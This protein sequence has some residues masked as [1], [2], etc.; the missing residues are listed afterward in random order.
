MFAIECLFVNDIIILPKSSE[1]VQSGMLDP[2][3]LFCY[4]RILYRCKC[5]VGIDGTYYTILRYTLNHLHDEYIF[6]WHVYGPKNYVI[7]EYSILKSTYHQLIDHRQQSYSATRRY[8]TQMMS[9]YS[10][11]GKF[12]TNLLQRQCLRSIGYRGGN[13]RHHG[14]SSVV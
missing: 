12:C 8:S 3:Q 9:F 5:P 7:I 13:E 14:C 2:R 6:S 11:S 4:S 10:I 1:D